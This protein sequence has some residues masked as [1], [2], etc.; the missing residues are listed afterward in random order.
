M[1]CIGEANSSEQCCISCEAPG[2]CTFDA[3]FSQIFFCDFGLS[4]GDVDGNLIITIS[5]A[6]LLVNYIFA[7]GQISQLVPANADGDCFVS[8]SDA[9]YLINY[10]FAGGP[11][12]SGCW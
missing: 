1:F 5:D 8:I 6:V 10:I 2:V 3:D 9:V 12:P 7:G 11:A 4:C